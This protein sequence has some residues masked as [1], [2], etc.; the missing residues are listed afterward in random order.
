MGAD[1]FDV[2]RSLK[3]LE[4]VYSYRGFENRKVWADRST[5]NIPWYFYL[6]ALQLSDVVARWEGG[7]Q[8]QIQR[9]QEKADAFAVTAQGGRLALTQADSEG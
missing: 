5:L 3:L 7:T 4:E 2:R 9:L 8:E 6:T 1:W